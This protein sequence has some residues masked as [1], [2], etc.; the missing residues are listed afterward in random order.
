MSLTCPNMPETVPVVIGGVVQAHTPAML[1]ALYGA[2][3]I[4][5]PTTSFSA[6]VGKHTLS[7]R[8]GVPFVTN[9]AML[10]ALVA[11]NAPIV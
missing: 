10:A 5:T 2:A 11:Q 1:T 9:P 3:N 4:K 8:K 7:F 6:V